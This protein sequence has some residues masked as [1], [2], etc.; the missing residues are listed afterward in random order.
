LDTAV[1]VSFF[2]AREPGAGR[3]TFFGIQTTYLISEGKEAGVGQATQAL[4]HVSPFILGA[5]AETSGI[6]RL[7]SLRN[8]DA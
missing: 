4:E 2:L 3:H 6:P 8:D 5:A 7:V 1:S